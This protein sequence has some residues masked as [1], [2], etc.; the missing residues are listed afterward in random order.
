[1]MWRS[2]LRCWESLEC[3]MGLV[4]RRFSRMGRSQSCKDGRHGPGVRNLLRPSAEC[5][6]CVLRRSVSRPL[7]KRTEATRALAVSEPAHDLGEAG[8]FAVHQDTD[9]IDS[10][11]D[12]EDAEYGQAHQNEGEA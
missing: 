6:P 7:A 4:D 8:L 1:M 9:A 11:G 3:R 12:P 5:Q 2:R 10:A